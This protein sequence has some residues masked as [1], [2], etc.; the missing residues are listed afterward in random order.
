MSSIGEFV[1]KKNKNCSYW[2]GLPPKK[3]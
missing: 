3:H 1:K 2:F